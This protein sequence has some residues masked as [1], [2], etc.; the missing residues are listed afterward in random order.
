M[1][2]WNTFYNTGGGGDVTILKVAPFYLL[3]YIPTKPDVIQYIRPITQKI[4][5]IV[6]DKISI[7]YIDSQDNFAI[8]YDKQKTIKI[9]LVCQ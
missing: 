4:K 8:R 2:W 6:G 9:K 1:A 5:Y 7:R 3:K